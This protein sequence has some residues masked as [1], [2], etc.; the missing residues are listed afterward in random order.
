M[1]CESESEKSES[2]SEKDWERLGEGRKI[3]SK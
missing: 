2:E 3:G 1:R